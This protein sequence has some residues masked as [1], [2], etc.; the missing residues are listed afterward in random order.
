MMTW[1]DAVKRRFWHESAPHQKSQRR[2]Q[3]QKGLKNELA[4]PESV[5][6]MTSASSFVVV[7]GATFFLSKSVTSWIFHFNTIHFQKNLPDV[8][9]GLS[10]SPAKTFLSVLCE[11]Y[12]QVILA[13]TV[14]CISCRVFVT[15]TKS[16]ADYPSP[17]KEN[18]VITLGSSAY[19]KAHHKKLQN[20]AT[21]HQTAS[22]NS[23]NRSNNHQRFLPADRKTVTI[24]WGRW[25]FREGAQFCF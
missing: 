19:P 5:A 13:Q 24:R 4:C 18:F 8:Y 11:D 1:N 10:D 21:G 3:I 14:Y 12:R 17:G 9:D 22:K 25:K 23:H 16:A 20:R 6:A 7:I 15:E 2:Q